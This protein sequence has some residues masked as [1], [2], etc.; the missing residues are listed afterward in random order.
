MM[1][2]HAVLADCS[3]S[4]SQQPH[5]QQQQTLNSIA[6]SCSGFGSCYVPMQCN[7]VSLYQHPYASTPVS[8][9]DEVD[10]SPD[11]LPEE[12]APWEITLNM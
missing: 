7:A 6:V 10:A 1:M 3:G 2:M 12:Y 9:G 11:I 5:R 4:L 8:R